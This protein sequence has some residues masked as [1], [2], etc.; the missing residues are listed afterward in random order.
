MKRVVRAAAAFFLL[1]VLSY[2]AVMSAV[3]GAL[4]RQKTVAKDA[5]EAQSSETKN[6]MEENMPEQEGGNTGKDS[7]KLAEQYKE[8]GFVCTILGDSISKGYSADKSNEI[9]CYGSLVTKRIASDYGCSYTLENYSKN[10]LSSEQMNEKIL[11]REDVKNSLASSDLILITVGSNDLLNECKFAVQDILGM[12]TKF[13]SADEALGALEEAL[14]Q[15]PLLIINVINALTN[16]DYQ[17]FDVQWME[18]METVN[19]LRKEG[20]EVVVTN[21]Y[22]PVANMQMPSTMNQ[23]V[24]DIIG[25]MN[26]IIQDHAGEYEYDVADAA[27]SPVS[28]YVQKDGLHPDQ[29]GQQILADLVYEQYWDGI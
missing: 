15:N 1:I 9:E 5:V 10:G 4:G 28:G 17:S 7:A 18:M 25:N 12:D 19:S 20:A 22:N 26:K 3:T 11:V 2:S 14:K 8:N 6:D 13:K 29:D 23:V 21:I 16:W 27:N 24:E